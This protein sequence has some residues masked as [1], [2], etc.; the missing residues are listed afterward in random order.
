MDGFPYD[1]RFYL[2]TLQHELSKIALR[3][4]S[5]IITLV[6]MDDLGFHTCQICASHPNISPKLGNLPL[7]HLT[8]S[9]YHTPAF[10]QISAI[11]LPNIWANLDIPLQYLTKSRHQS[12]TFDQ[13][14]EPS[15]FQPIC[16][17]KIWIYWNCLKIVLLC[18]FITRVPMGQE[19]VRKK[20]IL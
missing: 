10:D 6:C 3:D 18:L 7:Q 12:P 13:I 1:A 16:F 17:L 14:W 2:G 11:Y 4:C 5:E 15:G 19:K 8:K 20:D 9:W